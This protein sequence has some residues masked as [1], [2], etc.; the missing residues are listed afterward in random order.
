[1]LEHDFLLVRE[2]RAPQLGSAA[3][4]LS[5]ESSCGRGQGHTPHTTCVKAAGVS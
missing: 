3:A 5:A 1:M 4:E 2:Q